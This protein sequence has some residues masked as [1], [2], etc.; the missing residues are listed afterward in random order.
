MAANKATFFWESIRIT[1][2]CLVTTGLLIL[3]KAS[4]NT[5]LVLFN[6]AVMSAAATFSPEKKSLS[7]ISEGI[8]VISLSILLG[9]ILGNY[10][11]LLSQCLVVIYA[12]LA[13]YLPK[14]NQQKNIFVTGALMFLIFVALPF[15]VD[16]A[17]HYSPYCLLL[18]A[19]FL[20]FHWL[21]DKHTYKNAGISTPTANPHKA[22]S[23]LTIGLALL[24]AWLSSFLLSRYSNL[25]H[26]YWIGLTILVVL[27][28]SKES[29]I[30]TT[31]IR[32]LVNVAG[33]LLV[34]LLMTYLVPSNFWI[35]F[36]LLTGLLFAIFAFGYSYVSRTLFIEMFVLSFTHLLGGYH[37]FIA[38]DRVILTLIGGLIVI[39]STLFIFK[40]KSIQ[41]KS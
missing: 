25:Q 21:F 30:K 32:I 27:Q 1:L 3:L 7:H 40:F 5:I 24:F 15:N 20:C 28:G 13:F 16:Q 8:I 12:A 36:C 6:I 26:L 33:A 19:V 10:F 9:G 38:V 4:E 35:N 29:T 17:L 34:V 23:S 41:S 31:L 14:T 22:A 39:A 18:L 2:A 37:N 11:P